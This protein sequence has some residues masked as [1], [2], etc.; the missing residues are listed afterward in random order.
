LTSIKF[1]TQS[2]YLGKII[3]LKMATVCPDV[4]ITFDEKEYFDARIGE[5]KTFNIIQ[6]LKF[7]K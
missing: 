5:C 4:L 6:T 2:R 3:G 7:V 1:E